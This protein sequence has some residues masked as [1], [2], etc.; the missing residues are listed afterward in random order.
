MDIKIFKELKGKKISIL[1]N[2]YKGRESYVGRLEKV[3]DNCIF[4]MTDLDGTQDFEGI[5]VENDIV[6]SIWVYKEM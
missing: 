6:L 5:W 1:I 4:I 2:G 3:K